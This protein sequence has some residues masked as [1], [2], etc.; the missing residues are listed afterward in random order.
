LQRRQWTQRLAWLV[1]TINAQTAFDK[2]A[3]TEFDNHLAYLD[4]ARGFHERIRKFFYPALMTN[5][6]APAWEHLPRYQ[7]QDESQPV[8]FP[9]AS[10]ALLALSA[11][12]L[13]GA[14]G[15]GNQ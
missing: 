9:L 7:F 12:L 15:K 13:F 3:Q 11:V 14:V 2:I 5:D 8:S 1:P 6:P 4:S 10:L